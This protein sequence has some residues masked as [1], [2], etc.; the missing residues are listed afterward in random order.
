[1]VLKDKSIAEITKIAE[2][3][4]WYIQSGNMRTYYNWTCCNSAIECADATIG[5]WCIRNMKYM[6]GFLPEDSFNKKAISELKKQKKDSKH[7]VKVMNICEEKSKILHNFYKKY[8]KKAIEDF[9]YNDF[10][11]A[12]N[13]LDKI[14]YDYWKIAYLCDLYDPTGSLLLDNEIK[15]EKV[16]LTEKEI[17]ILMKTTWLNY[18]QKELLELLEIES[19]IQHNNINK[20]EVDKLL[21]AHTKRYF[22]VDNSWENTKELTIDDFKRKLEEIHSSKQEDIMKNLKEDWDKR[23]EEIIK[24]HN[25]SGSLQ[26]VLFFFRQLFILR[27]KR[28]EHTLITNHYYDLLFKR[29]SV[30]SDIPFENLRV[31]LVKDIKPKLDEDYLRELIEKRKEF[32]LE[33]YIDGKN[34]LFSGKEA[35]YIYSILKKQFESSSNIIKGTTASKGDIKGTVRIIMGESHF[36]KFRKGDILVAPMTRPEYLPIMKKAIGII[37]DEGGITCHAA[38]VSRELGIPCIIGTQIATKTLRDGQL[39]ELDTKNGIIRISNS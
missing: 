4:K 31:L 19:D 30:L 27:D 39:V 13:D 23:R 15:K 7:I 11:T 38:I 32:V 5:F 1:M 8:T 24:K 28:K 36:S 2:K 25:I 26:N 20:G 10:Y 9:S 3:N 12:L 29:L 21:K 34:Q 37:T 35:E 33:T 6:E 14:N 22:Y 18:A 17:D 16:N